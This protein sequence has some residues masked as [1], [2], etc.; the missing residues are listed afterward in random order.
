MRIKGEQVTMLRVDNISIRG[1]GVA[2]G[3]NGALRVRSGAGL[4][5]ANAPSV[6]EA[7]SV[8]ASVFLI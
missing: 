3:V 6:G 4:N 8:C 7:N 2:L 5:R 1:D